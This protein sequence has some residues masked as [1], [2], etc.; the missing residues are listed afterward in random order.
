[1]GE[2]H[3][4]YIKQYHKIRYYNLLTSCT[5]VDYLTD[6]NE[7]AEELFEMYVKLSSVKEGVNEKLKKKSIV[8]GTVYE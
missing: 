3:K 8:V 2:W 1:M 6:I 5:L 7:Q 4:R